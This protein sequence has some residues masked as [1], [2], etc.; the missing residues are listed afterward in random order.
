MNL[1]HGFRREF[2]IAQHFFKLLKNNIKTVYCCIN[3]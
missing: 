1:H 3:C 2:L